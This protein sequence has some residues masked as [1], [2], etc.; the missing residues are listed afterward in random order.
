MRL[1]LARSASNDAAAASEEAASAEAE[2][3]EDRGEAG[4]ERAEGG[5]GAA[6]AEAGDGKG[7]EDMT[8]ISRNLENNR[9]SAV[10]SRGQR[11]AM[12]RLHLPS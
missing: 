5:G 6:A 1:H 11:G 9:R 3:G 12:K 2:A 8:K 4:E 7:V 10:S